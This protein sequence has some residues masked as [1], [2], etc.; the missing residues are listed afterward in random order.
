MHLSAFTSGFQQS[1][2]RELRTFYEQE[3]H[4]LPSHPNANSESTCTPMY[5]QVKYMMAKLMEEEAKSKSLAFLVRV[6]IIGNSCMRF[7]G[8]ISVLAS[9]LLYS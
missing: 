8:P 2:I 5:R 7:E 4:R 1:R 3:S 9:F 6:I